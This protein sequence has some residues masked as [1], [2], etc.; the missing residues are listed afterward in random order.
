MGAVSILLKENINSAS[1]YTRWLSSGDVH[2]NVNI[3]PESGAVISHGLTK[4]AV[5][6]DEQD[7]FHERSAVCPH[8]GGIVRWNNSEKTWD[9]PCHGSRFSA[10]GEVINGP[11]TDDLEE[12]KDQRESKPEKVAS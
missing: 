10:F 4:T 3:P 5:Y 1:Q 9:C 7:R 6:R 2:D 11:A 12:I 8:M